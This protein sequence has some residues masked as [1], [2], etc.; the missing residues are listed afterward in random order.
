MFEAVIA[1]TPVAEVL[2]R[3]VSELNSKGSDIEFF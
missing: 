2:Q 3:F 1:G